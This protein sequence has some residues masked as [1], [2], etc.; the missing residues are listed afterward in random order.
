MAKS[1][2]KGVKVPNRMSSMKT[3]KQMNKMMGKKKKG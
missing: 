1:K 3:S 2:P